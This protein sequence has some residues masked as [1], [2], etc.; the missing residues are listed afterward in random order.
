MKKAVILILFLIIMSVKPVCAKT[1]DELLQEYK[2]EYSDW[3]QEQIIQ[4][5]VDELVSIYPDK[6]KANQ[7]IIARA[8]YLEFDEATA[9]TALEVARNES[10]FRSNATN[11]NTNNTYDKGCWQINDTH[12]VS[13]NIRLNC[14]KST[15]WAI[16]KVKHN[17]GFGIWV[18]YHKYVENN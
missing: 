18:A 2:Q 17:G 5:K 16:N 13:D 7:R 15:E 1:V 10:G 4:K 11:I 12:H 6:N 14:K 3:K 8:F 9:R